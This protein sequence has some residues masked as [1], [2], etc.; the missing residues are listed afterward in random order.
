MLQFCP[1]INFEHRKITIVRQHPVDIPGINMRD[2]V[3]FQ[4]Y[5]YQA[6]SYGVARRGKATPG[7]C[8]FLHFASVFYIFPQ[9]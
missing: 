8:H 9:F 5:L 1:A 6:R 3:D 2:D 4:K 7:T